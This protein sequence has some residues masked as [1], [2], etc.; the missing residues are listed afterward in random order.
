MY[1]RRLRTI[2]VR[3]DKALPTRH[4]KLGHNIA[5]PPRA[6]ES[7]RPSL[8]TRCLCTQPWAPVL[9]EK[10]RRFAPCMHARRAARCVHSPCTDALRRNNIYSNIPKRMMRLATRFTPTVYSSIG[11]LSYGKRR[12]SWKNVERVTVH[13]VTYPIP[14]RSEH[15]TVKRSYNGLRGNF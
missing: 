13:S 14:G 7:G 2:S 1:L 11:N 4:H 5:S 3:Q 10:V 15:R 12:R 6:F 9:H 8:D